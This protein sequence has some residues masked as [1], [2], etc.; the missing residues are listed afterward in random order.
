MLSP[1]AS[2]PARP[3]VAQF[4]CGQFFVHFM[5]YKA[6]ARLDTHEHKYPHML[7]ITTGVVSVTAG[8]VK[9]DHAA[10][11]AVEIP[12]GVPHDLEALT[13]AVASCVHICRLPDGSQFPFNWSPSEHA[14][15][16]ARSSL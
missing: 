9:T 10:P 16:E 6:G 4:N 15:D 1:P 5:F 3:E 13:D 12:A 7:L 14:F 8:G 11:A 2:K